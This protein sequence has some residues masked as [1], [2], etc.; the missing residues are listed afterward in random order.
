MLLVFKTK[1]GDLSSS[2][3]FIE[4]GFPSP[5]REDL[6]ICDIPFRFWIAWQGCGSCLNRFFSLFTHF[7][8]I[9][10]LSFYPS[11]Q[12]SYSVSLH[13]VLRESCLI[14]S[15][16]F[17]CLAWGDPVLGSS[18]GVSVGRSELRTFLLCHRDPAL[19]LTMFL[20][21]SPI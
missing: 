15:C 18:F 3:W 13:F 11:L 12:R 1:W 21:N 2:C 8:V 10:F 19:N 16:S 6:W 17:G 9:F 4:V 5:L 7:S 14:C 20:K